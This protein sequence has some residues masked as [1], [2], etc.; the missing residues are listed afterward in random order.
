MSPR[1]CTAIV[2]LTLLLDSSA[3]AQTADKPWGVELATGRQQLSNNSPDWTET[4]VRLGHG[5]GTRKVSEVGAVRTERFGLQDEQYTALLVR[6]VNERLTAT[7]D[8][9]VSS[10][11]RV[12][13]QH[14]AGASLQYEVAPAW[15]VHGG[16]RSTWYNNAAVTQGSAMLEHYIS[17]YSWLLAWRPVQTLGTST[18]SVEARGNYYYADRSAI[19]LSVSSGQE[20]VVISETDLRLADVQ[21]VALT[22]RH[23]LDTRWAVNYEWSS[24]RYGDFYTRSGWRIGVQHLF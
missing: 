14:H 11:H 24:T 10:T 8:G 9:S 5:W 13:A 4:S 12:L 16:L 23:W 2:A 19:G 6:P 21:A 15:L 1:H 3:L 17:A 7:V 22:G 20:A 18:S